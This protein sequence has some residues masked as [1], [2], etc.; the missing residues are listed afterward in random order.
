MKNY[1][2]AV[3]NSRYF[4]F[5]LAIKDIKFKYRRSKLGGLWMMVQPMAMTIIIAFVFS[6]IFNQPMGDYAL[7]VLSGMV[8]W[9][10]ITSSFSAGGQSFISGEAYI[11]QFNH[12]KTIYSLK[13][14]IVF[15]YTFLI[16]LIGLVIWLL[17]VSPRN[18]LLGAITL[19]VNVFLLFCLSWS[20]TTIAAYTNV[21]FYDYPQL[22]TL[23]LQAVYFVSPIFLRTDSFINSA[24]LYYVYYLN[25]ITHVL[26]L[27]R[28]PFLYN[29]IPDFFDYVYVI[30]TIAVVGSI[31]YYLNRKNEKTI[32][33][34]L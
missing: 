6:T 20:V 15:I 19:P 32:I 8:V 3:Y 30:F 23:I 4:W 18:I 14:A 11:K 22:I 9:N 12:P 2:Q 33:Y 25:P 24:G 26:N 21:K 13:S 29:R 16:E 31:A 28:D 27:I 1:I 34:Y 17:F 5:Y 10:L 7:Y